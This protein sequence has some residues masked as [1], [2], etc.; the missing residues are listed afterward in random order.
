MSFT[1]IF[2]LSAL[3]REAIVS[4]RKVNHCNTEPLHTPSTRCEPL[5]LI[6]N[7]PV[8]SSLALRDLDPVRRFISAQSRGQWRLRCGQLQFRRPALRRWAE[9]ATWGHAL[10]RRRRGSSN[11]SVG[12]GSSSSSGSSTPAYG[13]LSASEFIP[14][15]CG[16][17][18]AE[19]ME[20]Q[21]WG[22]VMRKCQIK[23]LDKIKHNLYIFK[24]NNMIS[25]VISS[26]I[27][28]INFV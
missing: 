17:F 1:L 15:Q 28:G 8:S 26:F 25:V 24:K 27:F 5:R 10:G 14:E 12:S 22:W 18:A 16:E 7:C 3:A 19:H 21:C 2:L 11:I 9:G 13:H 4:S 23:S 6:A 20:S